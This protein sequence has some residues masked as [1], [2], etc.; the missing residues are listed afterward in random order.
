V[1][2]SPWRAGQGDVV[3]EISDA[4]RAHGIGFGIYGQRRTV[5]LGNRIW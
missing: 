3:R 5:S 4:C 1:K 2:N